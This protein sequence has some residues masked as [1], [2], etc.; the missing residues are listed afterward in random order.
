MRDLMELSHEVQETETDPV[1]YQIMFAEALLKELSEM[2]GADIA[3]HLTCNFDLLKWE[4]NIKLNLPV[5]S[6][7]CKFDSSKSNV[8]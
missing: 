3:P 6:C 2:K 8:K 7:L 4:Y 1:K 5:A